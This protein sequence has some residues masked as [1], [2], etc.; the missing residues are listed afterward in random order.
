M[1]P[2][3][4]ALDFPK[5]DEALDMAVALSPHVGGF[6]V[7]LELIMSAGPDAVSRVA[8][9]GLPV[10]ADVKLHDIPTT[11]SGAAREIARH[12]ARWI[13][14]HGSGGRAMIEAARSGMSEVAGEGTA[15]ILVVTV[16][17]SL[18][19]ADLAASG[20]ER[21]VL[22]QVEAMSRLAVASGA[23]GVICSP[24]EARA[25]KDA[26]PGLIAVTPG[27]RLVD[28]TADDQKRVVA[29]SEAVALGSDYLVVGRSITRADDPVSAAS[30][31]AAAVG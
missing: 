5:M 26:G 19:A 24:F 30:E 8:E 17:T 27:V 2:I 29:P 25:A 23:E 7:G 10:F 18:D 16:L 6:K 4:V 13:T 21:T 20:V 22:R 14:V 9:L 12:G 15:G 31:V 1:N 11:V 28:G 3:L